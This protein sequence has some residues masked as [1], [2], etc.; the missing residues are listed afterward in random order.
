MGN[1]I[2]SAMSFT[3]SRPAEAP[4][5]L[6]PVAISKREGT[7]SYHLSAAGSFQINLVLLHVLQEQFRVVLQPEELLTAFSGDT[8]EGTVLNIGGMCQEI[9]QH[10]A[11]TNGFEIGLKVIQRPGEAEESPFDFMHSRV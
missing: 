11:G 5:L 10:M 4:V 9:Q 2:R 3:T 7:N 6:L 8:D 1:R